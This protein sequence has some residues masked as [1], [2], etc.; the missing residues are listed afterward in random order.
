VLNPDTNSDIN[1]QKQHP[2][3]N[4]DINLKRKTTKNSLRFFY[5]RV[6]E[7]GNVGKRPKEVFLL[8]FVQ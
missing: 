3:T 4:S 2:D 1:I 8:L 6:G 5:K 7:G